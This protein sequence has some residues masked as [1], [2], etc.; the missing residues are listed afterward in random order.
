MAWRSADSVASSTLRR[1]Q[2]KPHYFDLPLS[3][4]ARAGLTGIVAGL[5]RQVAKYNVIINNLLPGP[6]E[7]ERQM[8]PMRKRAADAGQ[9]YDD[10]VHDLKAQVPVGRFGNTTEFGMVCAFLCS[11][12][13]GFIVGQNILS[14]RW[15][16][17]VDSMSGVVTVEPLARRSVSLKARVFM[18]IPANIGMLDEFRL[19]QMPDWR[20]EAA[21]RASFDHCDPFGWKPGCPS[22]PCFPRFSQ[23]TPLHQS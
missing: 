15:W 10:F 12:H 4:G 22:G 13:A 6:F 20:F 19:G 21:G 3:N 17:H 7:T 11:E 9:S 5:S 2:L 1:A 16:V 8:A 18:A 23:P 14:R